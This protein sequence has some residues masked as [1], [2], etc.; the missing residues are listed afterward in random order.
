M[1]FEPERCPRTSSRTTRRCAPCSVP[2]T[3]SDSH[4]R[5]RPV[6]TR[7]C[8]AG[9]F[10][11]DASE[12]AHARQVYS[13]P[14]GRQRSVAAHLSSRQRVPSVAAGA[15][16]RSTPTPGG[17][18]RLRSRLADARLPLRRAAP[19]AFSPLPSSLPLAAVSPAASPPASSGLTTPP[20]RP[21]AQARQPA[22]PTP[23]KRRTLGFDLAVLHAHNEGPNPRAVHSFGA[24]HST[25]LYRHV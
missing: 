14:G 6:P 20:H 8:R 22:H 1:R 19:A 12:L 17:L 9:R 21:P 23:L 3:P 25:G 18:A 2:P 10:R 11:C 24:M 13:A 4:T 7:L 5:K 15:P 16:S